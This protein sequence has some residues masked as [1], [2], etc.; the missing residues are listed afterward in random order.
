MQKELQIDSSS[1]STIDDIK[2]VKNSIIVVWIL[3]AAIAISYIGLSLA[4]LEIRGTEYLY[5][6][7]GKVLIY[8]ALQTVSSVLAML[9]Y[10]FFKHRKVL[11][12]Y[13]VSFFIS[14]ITFHFNFLFID[15]NPEIWSIGFIMI[16]LSVYYMDRWISLFSSFLVILWY[17][18]ALYFKIHTISHTFINEFSQ[19]VLRYLTIGFVVFLSADITKTVSASMKLLQG[20]EK[21][22]AEEKTIALKT[23][24]GV[25]ELSVNMKDLG[26]KN[27]SI[28][29]RLLNASES[30]ASSVEE[31]AASTQEFMSS[32]EEINKNAISASNEMQK[33]VTD[34]HQAMDV[35]K[36]STEEMISLVKFSKIMIES[37]ESI[38]EIDANTNLLA[39]NAAIEAARAGE[40]GKGFG[41]VATEIR[42][43][44][45]KSN[46]AASNV[47]NL[48]K[49]SENK[50]KNGASLNN[51]VNHMFT[52][53][54]VKLDKVSKVFQQISFATEELDKGGKE[55]AGGLEVINQASNQNLELSREIDGINIR[56]EKE[57]KKLNQIIKSGKKI[58]VNLVK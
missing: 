16:I 32:I 44:A 9:S 53:V 27:H 6:V 46:A 17:T 38:N 10:K 39:L 4:R 2:I 54:A 29:H 13:L 22:L 28:S 31:I 37:V 7:V 12:K 25:Q 26:E 15:I 41:V 57:T 56:F 49:E 1:Y 30:Q 36:G 18:I 5:L 51:K 48:L 50:I 42:K 52:D 47:G 43:L 45:E 33:I 8:A 34:V 3:F 14:T 19:M 35:I 24:Q 20:K 21:G 11:A 55:I 58:G 23:L 40:A